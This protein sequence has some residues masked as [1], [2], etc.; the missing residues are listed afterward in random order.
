PPAVLFVPAHVL[1][2]GTLPPALVTVHDL[3]HRAYPDTHTGFQRLYLEWS[4][5]RHAR[6]AARLI[7]DS[8]S[9]ARDL[10][11]WYA[12]PADRISVAYLGVGSQFRPQAA[13]EV[14]AAR[15]A[16]GVAAGRR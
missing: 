6:L 3:G 14:D 5:R 2:S 11:R 15:A 8:Q 4:T 10:G 1:P 13:A 7:A 16:L 12:V 9:T